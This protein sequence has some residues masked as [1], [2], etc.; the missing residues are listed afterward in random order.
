MNMSSG[1]KLDMHPHPGSLPRER[2]NYL[3]SPLTDGDWLS[4]TISRG[5]RVAP[6]RLPLLGG[7]GRGEGQRNR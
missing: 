5:K 7:E 3:P 2:E 4:R 6:L 1:K